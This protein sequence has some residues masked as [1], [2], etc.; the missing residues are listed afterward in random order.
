MATIAYAD[1]LKKLTARQFPPVLL[2]HGEEAFFTD[3][4][5][6]RIEESAI[7]E[8][9]KGFNQSVLY[10][11]ET[12][13][14]TIINAAR[15]FPMM[16]SHQLVLIKEA[17]GLP[18]KEFEKLLT[19]FEKPL[20]STFLVI[21]YKDKN[22]DKRKKTYK[23]ID[24]KGLVFLSEKVKDYQL[25][26]WIEAHISGQGFRVSA[27]TSSIMA[28]Y[29]GNNLSRIASEIEKLA[30][31]L[32]PGATITID[33]IEKYIGISRDFNVFEL[34]NAIGRRDTFKAFQ[35]ANYF[36]ESPKASNFNMP[37]C[38]GSLYSFFSK[39][40][41]YHYHK[42]MQNGQLAAA[43]GVNPYFLKDYDAYA[44]NFSLPRT[45]KSISILLE[46]DLK[47][48]GL[49]SSDTTDGE[50]LKEMVYKLLA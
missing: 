41:N 11:R 46:Y 27:E 19:Y 45:K 18:E 47:S 42:G 20:G 3:Q 25:A 21:S 16:A 15:R 14:S 48:K 28:E 30:I 22:V 6:N 2:L 4:L 31:N 36:A 24:E 32:E 8:D 49:G 12:D 26:K 34:Q 23:L 1:L 40:Y 13:A 43:L 29:L 7:S 37:V 33:H 38:I 50:L 39:I 44:K 17:Q 9:Q 10:G 35:I 5:T